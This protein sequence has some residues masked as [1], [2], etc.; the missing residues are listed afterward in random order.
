MTEQKPNPAN[1]SGCCGSVRFADT[2]RVEESRGL[3]DYG[4]LARC[5]KCCGVSGAITFVRGLRPEF[6]TEAVVRVLSKRRTSYLTPADF[7]PEDRV[8]Y[9]DAQTMAAGDGQE[10]A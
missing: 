9:R 1:L 2:I 10:P 5:G 3:T 8:T 4:H 6:S 7:K